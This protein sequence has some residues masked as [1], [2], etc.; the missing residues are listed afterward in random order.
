MKHLFMVAKCLIFKEGIH[1]MRL[2]CCGRGPRRRA[3]AAQNL[4]AGALLAAR[5]GTLSFEDA[6][7][8]RSPHIRMPHPPAYLS[9][10][11]VGT[12]RADVKRR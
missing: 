2:R 9:G 1:S 4:A 3:F 11:H 5:P 12:R 7:A 6:Q 10:L 8:L